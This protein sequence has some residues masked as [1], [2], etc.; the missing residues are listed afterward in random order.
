VGLKKK[1]SEFFVNTIGLLITLGIA[2]FLVII[3]IFIFSD[4]P[5]KTIYYFLIGPFII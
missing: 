3:L 2:F 4:E 1:N 5:G